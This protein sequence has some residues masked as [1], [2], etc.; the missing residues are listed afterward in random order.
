[1]GCRF[2]SRSTGPG[3]SSLIL[4]LAGLSSAGEP[5]G[6]GSGL[7]KYWICR[8]EGSREMCDV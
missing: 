3:E 8:L 4:V 5:G 1:M 7:E 2:L 6:D